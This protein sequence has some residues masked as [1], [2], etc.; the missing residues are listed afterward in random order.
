[1]CLSSKTEE[2]EK[3]Q[4]TNETLTWPTK[5]SSEKIIWPAFIFTLFITL[6][7]KLYHRLPRHDM[8]DIFL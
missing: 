6:T 4:T 1:M 2:K 3:K 8:L 5:E 7:E